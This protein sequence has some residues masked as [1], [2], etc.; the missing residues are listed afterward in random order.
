MNIL[1]VVAGLLL[2]TY[3]DKTYRLVENYRFH[4]FVWAHLDGPGWRLTEVRPQ[5]HSCFHSLEVV[6]EHIGGQTL[7]AQLDELDG[8]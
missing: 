6:A 1:T 4:Q 2:K 3:L 8:E 7:L 5:R